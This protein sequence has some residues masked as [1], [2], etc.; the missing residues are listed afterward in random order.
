MSVQALLDKCRRDVAGCD[1]VAF[2]DYQS[3]LILRSSQDCHI[4]REALDTLCS[5]AAGGFTKLDA[6]ACSTAENKPLRTFGSFTGGCTKAFARSRNGEG[7]FICISGTFATP[8]LEVLGV[9]RQTL[10]KIEAS[11]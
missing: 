8:V 7:E 6:I 9:A 3:L 11:V 10:L 5:E 2:G 4:R 1:I